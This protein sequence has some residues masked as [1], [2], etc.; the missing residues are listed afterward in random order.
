MEK[1]GT[2]SLEKCMEL[3]TKNII[4]GLEIAKGGI[5]EEDI[6]HLPAAFKNIQ[7]LVAFIAEKPELAQEIKDLDVMEGLALVKKGYDSYKQ[8]KEEIKE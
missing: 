3:G 7:E 2:E 1:I 8:I 4:L 5:N 6:V